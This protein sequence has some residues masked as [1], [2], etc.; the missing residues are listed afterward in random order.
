MLQETKF[1]SVIIYTQHIF[2]FIVMSY[3]THLK[4]P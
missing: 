2:H 4:R 3:Q 1:N